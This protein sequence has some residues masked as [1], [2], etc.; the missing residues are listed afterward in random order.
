M[1]REQN[2]LK[3]N[4]PIYQLYLTLIQLRLNLKMKG[5]TCHLDLDYQHLESLVKLK[6][7]FA[8]FISI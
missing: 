1:T 8:F 6:L 7:V 4:N 2:R 3:R 5:K